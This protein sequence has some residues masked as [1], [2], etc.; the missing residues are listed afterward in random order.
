[1]G[2]V[3]TSMNWFGPSGPIIDPGRSICA[4]WWWIASP[5]F[6]HPISLSSSL[7]WLM[8]GQQRLPHT[9]ETSLFTVEAQQLTA[10]PSES[11][12][13][14]FFSRRWLLP[15][16]PPKRPWWRWSNYDFHLGQLYSHKLAWSMSVVVDPVDAQARGMRGEEAE[17]RVRNRRRKRK[18]EEEVRREREVEEMDSATGRGRKGNESEWEMGVCRLPK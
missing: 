11:V 5:G 7:Q 10:M 2:K 18:Q 6:T 13:A 9:T 4:I 3:P 12:E 16:S 1:M 17:R 14:A 15:P 8:L